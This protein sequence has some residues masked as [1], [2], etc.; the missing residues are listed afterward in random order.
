MCLSQVDSKRIQTSQNDNETLEPAAY[1]DWLRS[2][3]KYLTV[4]YVHTL[5]RHTLWHALSSHRLIYW[6]LR[7]QAIHTY[8]LHALDSPDCGVFRD[9]AEFLEPD[10]RYQS[11]ASRY[12]RA[13]THVATRRSRNHGQESLFEP[14]QNKLCCLYFWVSQLKSSYFFQVQKNTV[15]KSPAFFKSR[16]MLLRAGW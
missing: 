10:L 15:G 6:W 5:H 9:P 8:Y 16:N 4:Y 2:S 12:E 3:P 7:N 14:Y 1:R 13:D 11:P